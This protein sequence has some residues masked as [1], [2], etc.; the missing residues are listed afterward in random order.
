MQDFEAI[1]LS[2][3]QRLT[4]ETLAIWQDYVGRALAQGAAT[5]HGPSAAD[6]TVEDAE[7]H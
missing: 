5:C 7:E 1:L 6:T 3:P 4:V 2:K